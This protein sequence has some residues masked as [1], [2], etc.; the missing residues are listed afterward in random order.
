MK[1]VIRVI[2]SD[3]DVETTIDLDSDGWMTAISHGCLPDDAIDV[4]WDILDG[5]DLRRANDFIVHIDSDGP[6]FMFTPLGKEY[7]WSAPSAWLVDHIKKHTQNEYVH[8]IIESLV[9]SIDSDVIVD[10]FEDEMIA[11]GFTTKLVPNCDRCHSVET[12]YLVPDGQYCLKCKSV[13]KYG[14]D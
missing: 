8:R 4:V 7:A 5:Q 9:A 3:L 6:Q 13:E 11:D 14:G 12:L 2:T 1:K 10:V